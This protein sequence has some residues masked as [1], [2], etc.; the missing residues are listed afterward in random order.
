MTT[1]AT[2]TAAASAST[3]GPRVGLIIVSLMLALVPV[4]LDSLV[5][6]TAAPTIAGD[7]GGF[8]KL[9]WIATT[10]LLTM[11]VGT[12]GSGRIGDMFGRKPVLVA[13][14]AIFFAGSAVAALSSSMDLLI[15]ARAVQGLGAG[16][17]FTTLMAVIADIAPPEQRSR[18]QGIIAMVAPFSMIVGP[19]VGGVITDHLGWRWIFWL[20]LPLIGLALLGVLALLRLPRRGARSAGRVDLAGLGLLAVVSTGIVLAT[21][22]GG[23]QYAWLS[24]HVIGAAAAALVALVALVFVERR[25][26]HPVLPPNLFGD[27][28]VVV[29]LVVMAIAPGAIL[30]G[31][32][33]YMP[34]F[35]QLVQG[36]S[37]SNSG[38]LLL[39][40]LLPAIVVAAGTS[41]FTTRPRRFRPALVLG[42]TV[43]AVGCGLLATMTVST[44]SWVTAAFMVVVG[45]GVGLLFQTPL[46]LVQNS[47]SRE[48]VG[49]ATGAA[50]FLRML[51]GSIGVG[52]LG[53][54]FTRTLG[55]DLGG[56]AHVDPSTLTPAAVHALPAGV[57]EAIGHAVAA[58]SSAMFW[59]ACAV[60]VVGV[61]AAVLTPKAVGPQL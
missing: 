45:A 14:L 18:Y 12:I 39:P 59:A 26:T 16:M 17:T 6:A 2:S 40:V 36:R 21:T 20:N 27:R 34:V 41:A 23:H 57:Q 4:Q 24:A 25:A 9:A 7:L 35:L 8:S 56:K 55:D 19:W 42:T 10:Y 33:N 46:V 1:T 37:A 50:G 15:G 29:S 49:A 54:L 61:V 30:M 48:E 28:G 11:A 3:P 13:A 44:S 38:L 43:L 60:A 47:A 32:M 31:A 52:A 51:G 58:G 53:T 22:W 5:A